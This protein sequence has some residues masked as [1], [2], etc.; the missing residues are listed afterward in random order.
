MIA[1]YNANGT[2]DTAYGGDGTFT[3]VLSDAFGFFVQPDG[4]VLIAGS[5]DQDF[6]VARH[7][8]DGSLDTSFGGGDGVATLDVRVFEGGTEYASTDLAIGV[9]LQPEEFVP[10]S[11]RR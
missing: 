8:A 2:P 6:A 11:D 3:P 10:C 4:K 5:F 1:R 9:G 7:N